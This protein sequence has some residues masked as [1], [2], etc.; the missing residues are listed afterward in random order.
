MSKNIVVCCDGTGNEINSHLSNV[1]KLY[2]MTCENKHQSRYYDPGV[3]TLG[4]DKPWSRHLLRAN[5]VFGLATG[6]GLDENILDAYRYLITNYEHG[7]RIFLFGFSRGA[8]TIRSLAGLV[9][10]IGIL[11]PEQMNLANYALTA[12]RR[13]PFQKNRDSA[14]RFSRV[15][16]AR[17]AEIAFMG[18]W[19][20][21]SSIIA[22]RP[23]MFL[24]ITFHNLPHTRKNPAV[25]VV[26]QAAAIDEKRRMFRLS[27]WQEN[28]KFKPSPFEGASQ[29]QDFQQVWFAGSHSD[30]G[31]GYPE[32][33]SSLAKYPLEWMIMEARR[34][35]LLIDEELFGRLV[36]GNERKGS[37][38]Q[39]V[40][41][42]HKGQYHDS[43][44]AA[45]KTLEYLPKRTKWQ[46]WPDK[47][48][49]LG[50]YIPLSELRWINE[51]SLIHHS[52]IDRMSS[53][54]NYRPIN[55]PDNYKV[56]APYKRTEPAVPAS[57]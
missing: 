48:S 25:K 35:G 42:D 30:V 5:K 11:R 38:R 55:L 53:I 54:A 39:Y 28:Q 13:V 50:L 29:A 8:Y 37:K 1:L 19:D 23:D 51:G 12:Y 24:H 3:G 16:N 43:M 44:S 33:E 31:G 32:E 10:Q 49:L 52:V 9:Y 7:D 14:W 41:P 57:A 26:R 27:T 45:W 4:N 47:R 6:Q 17:R 56:V 21:V 46:Q 15:T 34:K 18:M 40:G 2:R 22:P 36:L 20:T